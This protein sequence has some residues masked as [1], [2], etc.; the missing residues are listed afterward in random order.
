MFHSR[1][2]KAHSAKVRCH[3]CNLSEALSVRVRSHVEVQDRGMGGIDIAQ[4]LPMKTEKLSNT[5][6]DVRKIFDAC[7]NS[8]QNRTQTLKRMKKFLRCSILSAARPA[9]ARIQPNISPNTVQNYH[10]IRKFCRCTYPPNKFLG[11]RSNLRC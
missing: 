1:Y 10:V 4:F 7:R 9:N 5:C 8:S 3:I 2:N 11:R 6:E